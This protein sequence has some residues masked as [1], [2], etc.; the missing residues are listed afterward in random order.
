MVVIIR[1]QTYLIMILMLKKNLQ[2]QRLRLDHY[3]TNLHRTNVVT[4]LFNLKLSIAENINEC[5]NNF[6][7]H[8]NLFR[9]RG[10]DGNEKKMHN[11]TNLKFD[12]YS[13][14]IVD[15]YLCWLWTFS[16]MKVIEIM[17]V[18]LFLELVDI[19]SSVCCHHR[20]AQS[21]RNK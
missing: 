11:K 12:C 6:G 5:E 3:C 2:F 7:E 13:K 19:L 15:F 10:Q 18:S 8:Q 1:R 17:P 16:W 14:R 4:N 21:L 9:L 20:T